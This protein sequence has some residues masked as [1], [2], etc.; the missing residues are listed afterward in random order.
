MASRVLMKI[1]SKKE[2]LP[3]ILIIVAFA[4][5]LQMYP[6]LPDQVP[7]HWN[8]QGE[9]DGWSSKNFFVFFSPLLALGIYLLMTLVPLLDPFRKKYKD[10][11]MAY[12]WIKTALVG[13]LLALYLYTIFGTKINIIYFIVP[14]LSLLWIV[15][16]YFMPKLKR[17]YFIGIRTPWTIHSEKTWNE[18]H[19]FGGRAFVIA[20]IL[21]LLGAIIKDYAF[22]I[23]I[24]VTIIAGLSPAVYSYFVFKKIGGFRDE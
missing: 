15:I 2:I 23:F 13:F 21:S 17:N 14:I 1:F 12:Y 7:T 6:S 9:I 3:I 24:T 19:K 18:T 11:E 5:G 8:A 16:G 10:F 22:T 20:G 4:I